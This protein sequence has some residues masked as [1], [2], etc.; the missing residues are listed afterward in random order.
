MF[1]FPCSD[2]SQW[3]STTDR[4]RS[5]PRRCRRHQVVEQLWL[6]KLWF[7]FGTSLG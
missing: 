3:W 6:L 5:E 7:R 2:E 4:R 1:L